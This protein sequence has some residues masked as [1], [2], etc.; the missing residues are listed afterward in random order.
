MILAS[1]IKKQLRNF[2]ILLVKLQRKTCHRIKGWYVSNFKVCR[3]CQK[4]IYSRKGYWQ[5]KNK[6]PLIGGYYHTECGT[7]NNPT[8]TGLPF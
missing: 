3:K 7:I 1:E 6:Y 2:R 5:Y 8:T 4:K